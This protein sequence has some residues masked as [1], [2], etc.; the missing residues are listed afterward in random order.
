MS[1]NNKDEEII[2]VQYREKVHVS[3]MREIIKTCLAEKL[4]GATYG[5]DC[6]NKA[7]EISDLVRNRLK[8]LGK[9]RYKFVVQVHLGERREQGNVVKPS[10]RLAACMNICL[11]LL[12]C[13]I[14]WHFSVPSLFLWV[15]LLLLLLLLV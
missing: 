13:L 15:S 7:K 3:I 1:E 9:D 11:P 6:V 5:E 4:T 14:K 12:L 2:R 8:E 10:Y